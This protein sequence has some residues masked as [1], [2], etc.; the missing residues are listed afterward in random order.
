L[1]TPNLLDY[2]EDLNKSWPR[3]DKSLLFTLDVVALYPSISVEMALE[4]MDDA[5]REDTI[6]SLETKNVVS[7]FSDFILNQSFVIF[8]KEAYVG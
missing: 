2:V 3:G 8:E 1:D 7:K 5:F 6:H 4:A